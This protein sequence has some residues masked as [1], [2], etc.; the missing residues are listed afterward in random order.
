[1]EYRCSLSDFSLNILF[2]LDHGLESR[3]VF[4]SQSLYILKIRGQFSVQSNDGTLET[5]QKLLLF[6]RSF[7]VASHNFR[8]PVFKESTE[9]HG[10]DINNIYMHHRQV[11]WAGNQ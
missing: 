2:F 8:D 1:M 9:L 10:S 11:H 4:V 3:I 6:E 7:R 5:G